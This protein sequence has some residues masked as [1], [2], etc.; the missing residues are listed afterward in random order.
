V[1]KQKKW[2]DISN[3]LSIGASSSAGFTLKKNYCKYVLPY[4]CRYDLNN[5]D[6]APIAAVIEASQKKDSRKSSSSG[7]CSA[8]GIVRESTCLLHFD[9]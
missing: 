5:A 4:E 2:R 1:T 9:I 8:D 7:T 3:A 6:P